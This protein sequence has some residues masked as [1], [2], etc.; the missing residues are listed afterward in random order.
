LWSPKAELFD[1]GTPE[2]LNAKLD[3]GNPLLFD[4]LVESGIGVGQRESVL[5]VGLVND[6][7]ADV[8]K[9]WRKWT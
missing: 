2:E 5:S 8:A 7:G 9:K 1:K 4:Y 6:R 3:Q